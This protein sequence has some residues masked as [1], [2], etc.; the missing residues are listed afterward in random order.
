MSHTIEVSGSLINKENNTVEIPYTIKKDGVEIRSSSTSL[1]YV[2]SN[3]V[4]ETGAPLSQDAR[5]DEIKRQFVEWAESVIGQ[6]E[7]A[8]LDKHK[9]AVV[10]NG[11]IVGE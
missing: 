6:A 3:T 1:N 5:V 10:M 8:H 4:D 7:V 9:L 2:S 11:L